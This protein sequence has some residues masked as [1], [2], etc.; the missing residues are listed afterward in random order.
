MVPVA[1]GGEVS[2][3]QESQ[4]S[5][6]GGGELPGAGALGAA[7][8]SG[9]AARG[10]E[11]TNP[12]T[13]AAGGSPNSADQCLLSGEA[14]KQIRDELAIKK[15]I[16]FTRPEYAMYLPKLSVS[17]KR[18]LCCISKSLEILDLIGKRIS[19]PTIPKWL[20]KGVPFCLERGS[21]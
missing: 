1:G 14:R 11:T 7:G 20:L 16:S 10:M 18:E 5:A 17:G 15:C 3:D 2:G 4:A 6:M 19:V 8:P 13:P 12:T 21:P 9:I